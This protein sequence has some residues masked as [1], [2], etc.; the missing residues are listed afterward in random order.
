MSILPRVN[1]LPQQYK[2]VL[3]GCGKGGTR[4]RPPNIS[5]FLSKV[6]KLGPMWNGSH[7]WVWT[8]AKTWGYG[9]FGNSKSHG[10]ARAHKWYWEQIHGPVADGKQLDHLCHNRACVNPGH[11]EPV[12]MKENIRRGDGFC[13]INFRKTHCKYGHELTESNISYEGPDRTWRKCK[14]CNCIKAQRR[15]LAK[16]EK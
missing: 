6:D 2:P 7:C 3:K 1:L 8:G 16:K 10:T 11:L 14:R 4:Y 15:R 12:T 9:I 5:K 13:G